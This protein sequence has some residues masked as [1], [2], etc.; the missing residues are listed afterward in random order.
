MPSDTTSND[1]LA[2]YDLGGVDCPLCENRGYI[3]ER[4]SGL[5]DVYSHEC[6]CMKKRRSLRSLRKAGVEDMARRYTLEAYQT[7]TPRRTQI[8]DAARRFV[9]SPEGWFF[10]VGQ[11]GSGKTHICTAICTALIERGRELVFMPWVDES[12]RL[13]ASVMDNDTHG[14][15]LEKFKTVPVLYID[16]FLKGGASD[17]DLKLAFEIL[18]ARYNDTALRTII[19]SEIELDGIMKLDEAVGGRIYERSRGFTVKAPPEN[20]R[21]RA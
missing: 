21:L 15:R 3:I 18:N 9:E 10:I 13:K 6:A 4:G 12:K 2:E 5:F 19:S 7:D 11:T 14:K 20:W 17:A 16:D 1:P 8:K